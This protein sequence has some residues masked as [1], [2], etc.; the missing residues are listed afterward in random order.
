MIADQL[1]ARHLIATRGQPEALATLSSSA[2]N[3]HR[4]RRAIPCMY[5]MPAQLMMGVCSQAP[6]SQPGGIS[7][8]EVGRDCVWL[9]RSR[10]ELLN[11]RTMSEKTSP[12]TPFMPERYRREAARVRREAEATLDPAVREQLF[13]IAR[14]FDVVAETMERGPI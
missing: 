14:R 8:C 10:P 9:M 7:L 3:I 2:A 1:M 6:P 12:H 4:N 11:H 13:E 5:T